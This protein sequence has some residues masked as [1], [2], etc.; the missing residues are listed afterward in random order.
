MRLAR[1]TAREVLP[2]DYV[3]F[4]RAKGLSESRIVGVHVLKNIMI[5]I[6]TVSGLEFGQTVAFAVVTE[7]VFSWPGMGK[8]LIDSILLLDRPVV[9]AYLVVI[10]FFFVHAEPRGRPALFGARPAGPPRKPRAHDRRR[11]RPRRR[12]RR[13]Q[14]P[15]QRVVSDFC[16][17]RLAVFGLV[18]VVLSAFVALFAPWISPQNPFDIAQP[19]PARRQVAAGHRLG[20]RQDDLLAGHRRPGARHA[21]GDLLRHAH[22]PVRRLR[23]GRWPRWPSASWSAWSRP[24]PAAGSTRS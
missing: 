12:A 17:N 2:M 21:V 7:T 23:L 24:M 18:L 8:L 13:P 15:F 16:E 11:A 5:P 6:A 1:A 20:R 14:T 19:R 10:V 4:A 22:Q 9:V 3:K